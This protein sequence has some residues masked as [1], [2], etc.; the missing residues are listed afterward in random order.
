ME[1]EES[2]RGGRKKNRKIIEGTERGKE[3]IEVERGK[4]F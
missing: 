4:S 2:K 1:K 3:R